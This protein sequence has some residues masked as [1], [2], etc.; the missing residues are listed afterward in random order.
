M[1]RHVFLTGPP[2]IGKT[3]LIQ[4]VS[5]VLTTFK[6]H[7]D[8]FYTEE[9]RLGQRRV[10]FDVV[11]M[12]GQRG[13]L[14]RISSD[15]KNENSKYR[16][17]QYFVD[18]VSFEQ[19]VLPLMDRFCMVP[20]STFIHRNIWEVVVLFILT[21]NMRSTPD[22]RVRSVCVIDEIG[23]MELFSKPFILDIGKILNNPSNVVLG[24]LPVSSGR[25]LPFVEEVRCRQ[26]V[27][28]FN[29]ITFAETLL[30][31]ISTS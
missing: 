4:K 22:T 17:G 5:E 20:T 21:C 16:V 19:L 3:T 9:V 27:K 13:K 23:K 14:A 29:V 31:S 2:G 26:D 28:L 6:V 25:L 24:T 30:K 11:T 10:G 1:H 15:V 8:G 7:V 12:S 18:I